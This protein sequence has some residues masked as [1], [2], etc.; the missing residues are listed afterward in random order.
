MKVVRSIT[1]GILATA[2]L[3]GCC[4]S[5]SLVKYKISD[6]EIDRLVREEFDGVVSLN[7]RF[8]TAASMTDWSGMWGIQWNGYPVVPWDPSNREMAIPLASCL[9]GGMYAWDKVVIQFDET[10]GVK[11]TRRQDLENRGDWFYSRALVPGIYGID[12]PWKELSPQLGSTS[13]YFES[14]GGEPTTK[15]ISA[16]FPNANRYIGI[17]YRAY[18]NTEENI[19][20]RIQIATNPPVEFVVV[21]EK[22][23]KMHK[24]WKGGAYIVQ[25]KDFEVRSGKKRHA[26][27][28]PFDFVPKFVT[29]YQSLIVL[30]PH[31]GVDIIINLIPA[32]G[33]S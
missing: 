3:A 21:D 18:S 22:S 17:V 2:M 29:E 8:H 24:N 10:G 4:K 9:Y 12:D 28:P 7:D 27:E 31:D 14:M 5:R 19:T 33:D 15:R 25:N 30:A 11:S 1:L 23:A 6:E 16:E 26:E 32:E 20:G 13:K